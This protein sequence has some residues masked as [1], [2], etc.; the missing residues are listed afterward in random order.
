MT[1]T[2][3][4]K[5]EDVTPEEKTPEVQSVVMAPEDRIEYMNKVSKIFVMITGGAV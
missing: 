4:A 1:H 3:K 5:H 2:L